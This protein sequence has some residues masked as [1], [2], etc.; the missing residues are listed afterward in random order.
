MPMSI[1][2][3]E[4]ICSLLERLLKRRRNFGRRLGP[5]QDM[6]KRIMGWCGHYGMRGG[7]SSQ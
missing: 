6:W 7:W 5:I 2:S 3:A 4:W 1:A